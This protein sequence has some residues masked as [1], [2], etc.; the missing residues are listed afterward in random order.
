MGKGRYGVLGDLSVG[1]MGAC[2]A[3]WIYQAVGLAA[4]AGIIG[5]MLVAFIGAVGVSLAQNK[6]RHL[7]G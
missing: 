7:G 5:A 3:V 2:V 4:H 6:L 1:L